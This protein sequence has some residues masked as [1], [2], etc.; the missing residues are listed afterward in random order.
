MDESW[1][2]HDGPSADGRD[3][4]TDVIHLDKTPDDTQWKL[5]IDQHHLDA[6]ISRAADRAHYDPASDHLT[7][8][9][10]NDIQGIAAEYLVADALNESHDGL[11][12]RLFADPSQPDVDIAGFDAGGN[13]VRLLQV[14]ATASS[15]Y[16]H[17][18]LKPGLEVITSS[19]SASTGLSSFDI[20][21]QQLRQII[22]SE[23]N[24]H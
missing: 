22:E 23:L 17:S 16:A 1:T 20:S 8:A 15:W 12:Y 21:S 2:L 6:A 11:E 4:F 7:P 13:I 19:D 5:G 14:K 18:A 24:A 10:V 3:G 9:F